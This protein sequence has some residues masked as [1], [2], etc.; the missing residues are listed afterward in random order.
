VNLRRWLAT[1]VALTG[2]AAGAHAQVG[3]LPTRSP[4]SDLEYRQEMTFFGGYYSAGVDPAGVAPR[5]GPLFGTRYD[6]RL[7]GPAYFT[8]RLMGVRSERAVLDPTKAAA[9]RNTGLQSWPIYLAD[10]G[11]ALN[12]TGFKSYHHLVPVIGAGLGVASDFKGKADVGLYKFGTPFALSF[13]A[14]LKWVPTSS[15]WQARLDVGEHLYQIKYP[16]SYYQSEIGA[17]IL[18]ASQS[19]NVWKGN[20]SITFGLSYLFFR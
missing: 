18:R 13:G 3:H 10:I 19:K 15:P 14:G 17:P 2:T 11:F 6:L 4:Y 8:A 9:E 1:A 12:L 16:N 7:A 5:S 20:T